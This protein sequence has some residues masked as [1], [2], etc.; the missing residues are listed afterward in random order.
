MAVT[1]IVVDDDARFRDLARRMLSS[2]GFTA[3]SEAATVAGALR[4]VTQSRPDVALVDIGLPDGDGLH[5]S[6]ELTGDPW[7][8]RVILVSADSDASSAADAAEVG[9]LAFIPKSELSSAL[10][11]AVI[12]DGGADDR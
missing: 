6:R 8:M 1:V 2:W 4:Q 11:H 9:A 12:G 3:E 5:L 7:R 10:L